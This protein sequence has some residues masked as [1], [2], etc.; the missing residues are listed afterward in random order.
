MEAPLNIWLILITSLNI[1]LLAGLVLSLFLK[2]KEKQED[3]RITK[4]LQLLQNKLSILEDLSD[5]TDEQVRKLIHLLDQKAQEVRQTLNAADQKMNQMDQTTLSMTTPQL[6]TQSTHYTDKTSLYVQAAKLAN[7]GFT[8]DQITQQVDLSP[9]ELNMI[10]KVNRDQL[11]FAPNKL[12]QWLDNQVEN[13]PMTEDDDINQF[14]QA[15]TTQNNLSQKIA[16]TA[17]DT[18]SQDLSAHQSLT[19][20]FKKTVQQMPQTFTETKNQSFMKDGKLIKPFE[21]KKI[22][23]SGR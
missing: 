10:I 15:I 1:L 22:T 20:D 8:V 16:N 18:M 23:T 4:G 12:P 19:E 2:I 7:Q 3:Q 21:F 17:F 6:Q 9:A 13:K 5:K 11:Q 14:A